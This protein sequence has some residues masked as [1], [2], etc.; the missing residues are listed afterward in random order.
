M[1]RPYSEDIREHLAEANSW[2]SCPYLGP[3]APL[4]PNLLPSPKQESLFARLLNPLFDG[5]DPER[6]YPLFQAGA[7]EVP[8]PRAKARAQQNRAPAFD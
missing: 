3:A 7:A 8:S 4:S 6:T 1:T 5:I 2:K